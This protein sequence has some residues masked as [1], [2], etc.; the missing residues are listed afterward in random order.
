MSKNRK[1]AQ[2]RQPG[3]HQSRQPEATATTAPS[4]PAQTHPA[5]AARYP[6]TDRWLML[7]VLVIVV[8][9]IAIYGPSL[10]GD[11]LWDDDLLV[12]GNS[13]VHDPA[14]WWRIWLVPTSLFD[15]LPLKVTVEWI[16]WHLW[17]DNP[18]PYRILNLALHLTGALL[19]WRLLAKFGLRSAWLGA[20]IFT[21][22]PVM[23]ESVAWIAELKNTLSLPIAL[24]AMCAWI[25]FDRDRRPRD[26]AL[27]LGLFLVTMLCKATFVMFPVVILLYAWWRHGRV[28]LADLKASAPFFGV[29]LV[30]GLVTVWF[31]HLHGMDSHPAKLGG[32]WSRTACAGLALS[33]YFSKAVLPVFLMPIYPLWNVDPP[34]LIQ[35][36]PWPVCAGV[37]YFLWVRRDGWGRPALFGLGFFV[38]NL[39]PFLGFTAGSYM[40]FTWT[41]DHILY[42]P[43]LGL[44]GLAVAGCEHLLPLLSYLGRKI[45]VGILAF[46]VG[47]M[48]WGGHDY[49]GD[50]VNQETLWSYSLRQNPDNWL[51]HIDLANALYNKGE[52]DA[53]F[54]HYQQALAIRPDIAEV[55]FNLGYAYYRARDLPKA[56]ADYEKA[57]DLNPNYVNARSNLGVALGAEGKMP[58]AI[59]QYHQA[60]HYDPGSAEAHND[61]GVTL[62][63]MKTFVEAESEL[64]KALAIDSGYAD[65]HYNL[66]NLYY[67]TGR[68]SDAV[69]EYEATLKLSPNHASAHNNLGAAFEQMGRYPE[70]VDEFQTALQLNPDN[71]NARPNLERAQREVVSPP[72]KPPTP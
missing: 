28:G 2:P 69:A 37:F 49:A 48:A 31:L 53:A 61:L 10:G 42:L 72:A 22:H 43:M 5:R 13:L 6:Q 36:L 60:L 18:L 51:A 58:E 9:G 19:L 63:S 55:Y 17:G 38:V 26:Y 29:S 8:A 23:V 24:C 32:A 54:A 50:Y 3:R 14:G 70:A 33:F 4:R 25:D 46:L 15:Y 68:L 11:W 44:I 65:A 45:A 41:M 64:K 16:E 30:L 7:K 62:T 47:L 34:R 67:L 20:L 12:T 66:G 27:A 56:I 35:F 71:A 59:E 21:V 39:L 1:R 52:L 40:S 57:I